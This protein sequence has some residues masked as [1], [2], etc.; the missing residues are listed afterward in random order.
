[1]PRGPAREVWFSDRMTPRLDWTWTAGNFFASASIR[2]FCRRR[3]TCTSNLNKNS[4]EDDAAKRVWPLLPDHK[5]A[6][7]KNGALYLQS[8]GAGGSQ[9]SLQVLPPQRGVGSSSGRCGV[10][11]TDFC[12]YA[13]DERTYGPAP[14]VPPDTTDIIKPL[15]SANSTVCGNTCHGPSDC[16]ST[17]SGYNCSCAFPSSDDARTLGLDPVVPAAVCLALFVTSMQSQLGGRD[18]R[19]YVDA[20]GL[21]HTCK[22]NETFTGIECCGAINGI[23]PT[24]LQM[25]SP[26]NMSYEAP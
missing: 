10:N 13:W 11:G 1:M 23:R 12:P 5:L 19:S 16:G 4:T 22:C 20:K 18:T 8:S 14:S 6:Q 24:R 15:N 17:D 3:C 21:P 2:F 7:F 26:N 9:S 25:H